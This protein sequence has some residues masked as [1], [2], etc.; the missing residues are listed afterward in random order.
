MEEAVIKIGCT[1]RSSEL[2]GPREGST[3]TQPSDDHK[4]VSNRLI[5]TVYS[6][7]TIVDIQ[8]ALFATGSY[9]SVEPGNICRGVGKEREMNK[10]ESKYTLKMKCNGNGVADDGYRWRKYG[11]K[12]IKNNPNRRSYYK[13]SPRCGAKKQVEISLEDPTLIITYEG[14]Y[15]HFSFPNFFSGQSHADSPAGKKLK[16]REEEKPHKLDDRQKQYGPVP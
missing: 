16:T 2:V 15:L 6:G 11:Q 9:A 7:P 8:K 1:N 12:I 13:C 10:G 4:T 5:S 14:L 3:P